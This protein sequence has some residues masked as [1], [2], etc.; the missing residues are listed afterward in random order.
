MR[1]ILENGNPA[2]LE[3]PRPSTRRASGG[4]RRG[5]QLVSSWPRRCHY[6]AGTW[7]TRGFLSI[8]PQIPT[9]VASGPTTGHG[10]D[11][12]GSGHRSR[13]RNREKSLLRR[14]YA[15]L[16]PCS[17]VRMLSRV[18]T[19]GSV[20]C[21]DRRNARKCGRFRRSGGWPRA[22]KRSRAW[23]P[24]P[25]SLQPQCSPVWIRP[26]RPLSGKTRDL[27]VGGERA[28]DMARALVPDLPC[29]A[30]CSLPEVALDSRARQCRSPA[31]R[32]S[33]LAWAFVPDL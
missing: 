27:G 9:S 2:D 20:R 19:A 13:S 11:S 29:G 18:L 8:W 3:Q 33:R 17:M 26:P 14:G 31:A 12:G 6:R 10:P 28:R 22:A 16:L 25:L 1:S 24:R 23:T 4:G 32:C 30:R 7:M 21:V 5:F 15:R